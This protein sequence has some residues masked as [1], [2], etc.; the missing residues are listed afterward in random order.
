MKTNITTLDSIKAIICG[1]ICGYWWYS[2]LDYMVIGFLGILVV[3]T[4]IRIQ[5]L[6]NKSLT[7]PNRE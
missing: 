4:G 7:L 6:I 2:G 1:V 5:I 3:I